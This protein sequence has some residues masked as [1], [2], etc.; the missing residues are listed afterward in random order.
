MDRQPEIVG[1]LGRA[2]I[3]TLL[4]VVC[5]GCADPDPDLVQVDD[6]VAR[7]LDTIYTDFG[8]A[9]GGNGLRSLVG[10]PLRDQAALEE[11]ITQIYDPQH[12]DFRDYLSKTQWASA[13]APD[14]AAV[15]EVKAWIESQGMQVPLVSENRLLME[16]T[17]TVEQ[18]N[19]AFNTELRVFERDSLKQGN[20]PFQVYGTDDPLEVPP[21]IAALISGVLSADLPAST[22][23][24]PGEAG[25]IINALPENVDSAMTIDDMVSAYGFGDLYSMG[26]RGAGVKV[27]VLAA[28]TFKFKDL[29][30]MWRSF[31]VTREDPRVEVTMEPIATRNLE[32]TLDVAWAGGLAPEAEL[33][34]YEGPDT[35]N[36]SLVYTFNAAIERA[37]VS[38]LTNSFA[39]AEYTEP[40]IVERQ[41]NASAMMGAALGITIVVASGDSGQP[42]VPS[43][44]P[45]VTCVGGTELTLTETGAVMTEVAW[46]ESGS[47][48][49]ETFT[50]PAWQEGVV[51]DS[52]GKRAISDV[53]M[54]ASGATPYWSYYLAEWKSYA[55]TSFA[56]PSFA[57]LIAVV[58]SARIANGEPPAGYLN[59]IL[60]QSPEVQA[61][62]RDIVEGATKNYAAGPGWDYPTGWGAPR[63]LELTDALP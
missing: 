20:P 3:A 10:F 59:P 37:E 23:S 62:F 2:A 5:A 1:P 22:D 46:S 21:R 29:Q 36:T 26:H 13:H 45:F 17:G 38:V 25:D 27:G 52:D 63:A 33:I 7:R 48:V 51:L 55:G 14:A 47:G 8:P 60:Y 15:D 12:P 35:R 56:A 40:P 54:N 42:D 30:S 4:A 34:V 9:P 18:F 58:N 6:G 49:S 19:A 31:G 61:A 16:I 53:A 41:Y 44:S 28:S 32:T 11:T 43:S 39:H 57:A 24:L 50:I